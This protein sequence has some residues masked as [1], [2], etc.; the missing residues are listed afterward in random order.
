MDPRSLALL[1]ARLL[2]AQLFLL[3]SAQKWLDPAIVEGLLAGLGWP[4]W[5]IWPA[6][7]F[8]LVAGVLLAL[9]FWTRWLAILLAAYCGVT[10]LF[11]YIPSDGWQM[12]IF[13]KNW[14]IA[15]G[16][17]ALAAAGPGRYALE[18]RERSTA[19][20]PQEVRAAIA[21]SGRRSPP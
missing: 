4:D 2:I 11:H 9:G 16:C 21:P 3:G 6:L 1:G 17:L 19:P 15:G 7:A 18:G 12:S 8:N 14:A 13:V 5:L 20:G 10:S